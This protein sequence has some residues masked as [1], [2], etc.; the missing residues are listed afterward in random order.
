MSCTCILILFS[1]KDRVLS[2][3][4][5]VLG[6]PGKPLHP[7]ALKCNTGI[8]RVDTDNYVSQLN[9]IECTNYDPVAINK[10]QP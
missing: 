4:G 1:F 10:Y 6:N 5:S 7:P 9:A 8:G 2:V 3:S